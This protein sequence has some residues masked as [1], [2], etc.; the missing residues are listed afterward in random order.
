MEIKKYCR[1]N[2]NLKITCAWRTNINSDSL[3][4]QGAPH[5]DFKMKYQ[6]FFMLQI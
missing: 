3:V 2:A 5:V 1:E 6:D 4:V